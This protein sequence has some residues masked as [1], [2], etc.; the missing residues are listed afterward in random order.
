MGLRKRLLLLSFFE[1]H[2]EC[3]TCTQTISQDLKSRKVE[4]EKT[5]IIKLESGL[6]DIMQEIT[7]VENELNQHIKAY[8]SDLKKRFKKK[9]NAGRA[10]KSKQVKDSEK[11]GVEMINHYA[12]TRRAYVRRTIAFEIA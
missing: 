12:A 4:E 10:L 9:E 11:T 3:P 8:V 5:T 6:Q 1:T 2:D 7:K